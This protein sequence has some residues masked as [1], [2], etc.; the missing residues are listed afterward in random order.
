MDGMRRQYGFLTS[1]IIGLFFGRYIVDTIGKNRSFSFMLLCATTLLYILGSFYLIYS[2]F[3]NGF[4]IEQIAQYFVVASINYVSLTVAAFCSIFLI[5]AAYLEFSANVSRRQIK[6]LRVLTVLLT[7]SVLSLAILFSTR[8]IIFVFIPLIIYIFQ[9]K[10]PF[11]ALFFF[12]LLLVAAYF[13][14]PAF[15]NLV[16]DLVVPGRESILDLYQSELKGQERS[17]SAWMIV[18]KAIP[19]MS[20]CTS[21]SEYLSFSAL[22]N[23]IALTFPFSLFYVFQLII[24]ILKHIEVFLLQAGHKKILF[25]VVILSFINTMIAVVFQADFLSLVALFFVVGFGNRIL[26]SMKTS[27]TTETPLAIA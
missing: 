2:N 20:F 5:W 7:L 17:E 3:K 8:T 24:F 4:S 12:I 11:K 10:R 6:I 27:L 16:L 14:F 1:A 13:I 9:P 15:S 18:E 21:C 26:Y 22:A 19:Y 25:L 23:L